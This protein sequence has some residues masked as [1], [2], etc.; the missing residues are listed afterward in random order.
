[1]IRNLLF[2]WSGTLADDLPSVLCAVNGMLSAAGV[3]ELT[4]AEFL[5]SCRQ[6]PREISEALEI[7]Q[8]SFL[9]VLDRITRDH[10]GEAVE[11]TT[12]FL[13]PDVYQLSVVLEDLARAP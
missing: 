12:H 11:M 7:S 13:R 3:G 2:D 8:S 9:L 1:M 4:R 10:V 6:P 5:V